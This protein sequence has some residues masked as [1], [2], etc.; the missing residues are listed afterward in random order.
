MGDEIAAMGAGI[1]LGPEAL[2]Q[3]LPVVGTFILTIKAM[4]AC[5]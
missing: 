2:L 5:P 4:D 3:A 1:D